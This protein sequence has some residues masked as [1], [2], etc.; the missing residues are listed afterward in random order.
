MAN[1][2]SNLT[3]ENPDHMYTNSTQQKPPVST[4]GYT[5]ICRDY[6][7]DGEDKTERLEAENR[8]HEEV[9]TNLI[10]GQVH[11]SFTLFSSYNG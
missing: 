5:D 6:G 4:P 10:F 9:L 1:N 3:Q 7:G 2:M 8:S 11:L